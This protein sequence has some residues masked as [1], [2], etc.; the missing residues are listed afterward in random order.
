MSPGNKIAESIVDAAYKRH[1]DRPMAAKSVYE[2]IRSYELRKNGHQVDIQS[3]I[4]VNY[5]CHEIGDAFTADLIVDKKVIIELKSVE[6]IK[7]V[8]K[9]QLM[10]YSKLTN[11]CLGLLINLGMPLIKE[12]VQKVVNNLP[13]PLCALMSFR[14]NPAP[15]MESSLRAIT[16]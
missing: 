15:C 2:R 7:P 5:D 9:K 11:I 16:S 14:E 4:N 1:T 10:T 12:G 3:S 13:E 6:Q 8:H